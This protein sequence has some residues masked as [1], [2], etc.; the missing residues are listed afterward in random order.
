VSLPPHCLCEVASPRSLRRGVPLIAAWLAAGW[1]ATAPAAAEAACDFYDFREMMAREDRP[2]FEAL[3]AAC[4]AAGSPLPRRDLDGATLL[5]LAP[6]VG[7]RAAPYYTRRLL[8]E[9]VDART[10]SS[11]G[12]TPLRMATRFGCGD[13]IG[14]LLAAG[15]DLN[16]RDADGMTPLHECAPAVVPVLL[17]AGADPRALDAQGNVPLHRI[18]HP[19]LL[20]PGIN[21][22]NHA[23]LTPLHFAA[24][25]GS[26]ARVDTLLQQGADP[27]LRSVHKTHWRSSIMSR[28]FGPG[29]EVAAGSTP[30]DLARAQQAAT[31]WNL[32]THGDVVA[33]LEAVTPQRKRWPWQ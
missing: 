19:A 25:A 3:V 16:E 31:R 23:G 11:D 6:H 22:R 14:L 10:P 21:V 5:F 27:A 2:A 29:I 4:R 30:L 24:L 28:A 1:L 7:G 17:A 33:R 13:C 9:G 12:T 32:Q 20:A 18:W 15:A 8:A 26:L